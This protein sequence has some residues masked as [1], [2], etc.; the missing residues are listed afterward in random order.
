MI[1]REVLL[2]EKPGKENTQATLEAACRRAKELGIRHLVVATST[3][4]TALR[5]AQVFAGTDVSIVG[6][7]LHA[8]LWEKYTGPD[9]EKV[10]EAEA[11]GGPLRH[12]HP[13]PD[14]QRGLSDP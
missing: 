8:G 11:K 10:A 9:A 13:R 4:E 5:A 1:K 6:V 7:T 12:G 3:G 14:G 2:F